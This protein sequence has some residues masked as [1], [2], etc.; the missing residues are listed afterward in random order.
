MRAQ[1]GDIRSC[2]DPLGPQGGQPKRAPVG[3]RAHSLSETDKTDNLKLCEYLNPLLTE[4][5]KHMEDTGL[6]FVEDLLPWSE[7][8]P[9]N[10]RKTK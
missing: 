10:C 2:P 9:Q 6:D 7:A 5:P 1:C 3:A 8:L 4:I